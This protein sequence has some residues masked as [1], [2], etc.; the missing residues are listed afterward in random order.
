M[1]YACA[2]DAPNAYAPHTRLRCLAAAA[3]ETSSHSRPAGRAEALAQLGALLVRA[4][5]NPCRTSSW[6]ADHCRAHGIWRDRLAVGGVSNGARRSAA[7]R[8]NSRS[9]LAQ[10]KLRSHTIPLPPG[11]ILAPFPLLLNACPQPV[12]RI[13]P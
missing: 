8:S 12:Q 10:H 7:S 4:A 11:V 5:I 9:A 6:S 13:P 2:S 1:E 3:L